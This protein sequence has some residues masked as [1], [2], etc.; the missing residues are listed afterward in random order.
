M[1]HTELQEG[2]I[3][4]PSILISKCKL[5][6]SGMIS[7]LIYNELPDKTLF[8]Y[9]KSNIV[10]QPSP[11]DLEK[12]SIN[13]EN[14]RTQA[15]F[16]QYQE[17]DVIY[18]DLKGRNEFIF[19]GGLYEDRFAASYYI[20]ADAIIINLKSIYNSI[21][22]T[23]E[24]FFDDDMMSRDKKVVEKSLVS[25][26]IPKSINSHIEKFMLNSIGSIEHELA[27]MIQYKYLKQKSEKQVHSDS[28]YNSDDDKYYTSNVE[29]SPQLITAKESFSSIIEMLQDHVE[30]DKAYNRK[31]FDFVVCISDL[32]PDIR[33][34]IGDNSLKNSY[35]VRA[36]I[37]TIK[38][39]DFFKS[40]KTSDK[41]KWKTAVKYLYTD[42]YKKGLL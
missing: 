7:T 14:N 25:Y 41:D 35:K 18:S 2:I 24:I 37:E 13:P 15:F 27:H 23:F 21:R 17:R 3:Q 6:L 19:A 8:E 36:S 28:E 31:L 39:R 42:L 1:K 10:K 26:A 32:F 34:Y 38:G 30:Y 22:N 11:G 12:Y 33:D 20:E 40:L 16:I 9:F 4:V 5:K 29:F